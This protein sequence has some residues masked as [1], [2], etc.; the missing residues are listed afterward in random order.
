MNHSQST[1]SVIPQLDFAM[2]SLCTEVIRGAKNPF[3]V[4]F[5]SNI[6]EASAVLPSLLLIATDCANVV[7]V[8]IKIR[9]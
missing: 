9:A 4:D 8:K 1:K 7:A 5:T 6:A 2:V 3:V